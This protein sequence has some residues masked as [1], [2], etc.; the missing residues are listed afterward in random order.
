MF[1][2]QS[3]NYFLKRTSSPLP[4]L[5][6]NIDFSHD[7]LTSSIFGLIFEQG[8]SEM[9][10]ASDLDSVDKISSFFGA[11]SDAY[12]ASENAETA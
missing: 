7:S 12:C 6:L 8:L 3:L 10:E 5:R 2:L 1:I 11:M 9:L 4:G